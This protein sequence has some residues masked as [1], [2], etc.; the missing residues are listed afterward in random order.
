MNYDIK[1][2]RGVGSV[3]K[4][5]IVELKRREEKR[6]ASSFALFILFPLSLPQ[7]VHMIQAELFDS[8][9]QLTI[10][11]TGQL[12]IL[13]CGPRTDTRRKPGFQTQTPPNGP[14]W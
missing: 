7:F 8:A 9:G 4:G 14:R 2:L 13:H 12:T 10:D 5:E 11:S 6:E 1:D 3:E